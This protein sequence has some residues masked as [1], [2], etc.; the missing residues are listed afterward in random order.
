MQDFEERGSR[1]A[2]LEQ[3][4]IYKY[5]PCTIQMCHRAFPYFCG[6]FRCLAVPFCGVLMDSDEGKCP[7]EPFSSEFGALFGRTV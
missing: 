1:I 4:Q 2:G 6:T 5:R 7:E 3:C